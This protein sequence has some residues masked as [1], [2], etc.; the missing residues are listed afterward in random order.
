[1]SKR[2]GGAAAPFG[3][4][5]PAPFGEEDIGL[6]K[7]KVSPGPYPASKAPP[8]ALHLNGFESSCTFG[9]DDKGLDK[10]KVW[11]P[12]SREPATVHRTVAL[13]LFE[14]YI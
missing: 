14:S 10:I 9:V 12:S 6:D 8:G 2:I 13:K 1:M 5:P 7:I 3:E 11:F 4:R